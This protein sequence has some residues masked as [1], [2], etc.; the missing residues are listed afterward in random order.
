MSRIKDYN[1][2]SLHRY[3]SWQ[4]V[5]LNLKR[6][7]QGL[8]DHNGEDSLR[9]IAC[10][11]G[12]SDG[13][14]LE[15]LVVMRSWW[16]SVLSWGVRYWD[17]IGI[18][19]NPIGIQLYTRKGERRKGYGRQVYTMLHTW[20]KAG[21]PPYSPVLAVFKENIQFW[22]KVGAVPKHTHNSTQR[23]KPSC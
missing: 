14:V 19:D 17:D 11:K 22:K 10:G 23:S 8:G 12:E 5:P 13:R 15:L 4:D 3:Y 2:P 9:S 6:Q 1:I 7:L 18:G 16:G 21:K 20:M